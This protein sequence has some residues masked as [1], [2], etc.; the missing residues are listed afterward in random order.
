MK[1]AKYLLIFQ[2]FGRPIAS[3]K[4]RYNI[5]AYNFATVYKV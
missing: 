3:F 1:Y 5:K 4:P 2:I